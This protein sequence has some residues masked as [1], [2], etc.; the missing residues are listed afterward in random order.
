MKSRFWILAV[1]AGLGPACAP[2]AEE[3]EIQPLEKL[4]EPIR[5]RHKLPALAA[6]VIRDAKVCAL[7]AVG[8]RKADANVPVTRDD[9][10]H[11]GS[12]TKAMTA[13]VL[14][15][16][17]D[18]GKLRWDMTLPEALPELAKDI[19]S[20]YAKATVR[21][22]LA[23]RAGIVP[24]S[25]P[26][27]SFGEFF[28]L[29]GTQRQQRLAYVREILKVPPQAGIGE[30]YIY[31]NAG[32]ATAG[33]IAEHAA[34]TGWQELMRKTLFVP[35]G[36]KTAGFGAMGTP[37]KI[38]QP[39]QHVLIAERLQPIGPGQM[40]DNPVVIDPAGRVHCSLSDWASFVIAHLKGPR[41]AKGPLPIKTDT[42]KMLH[43]PVF[44]GNYAMGWLVAARGWGGGDVLTHAGS[45]TMNYAVVWMAPVRD[46]AVLVVTNLGGGITAKAC[47]EAA[48]ALVRAVPPRATDE[49]VGERKNEK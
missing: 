20:G 22:V 7:G 8:V 1:L 48:A 30:K 40:S 32:Y 38:D 9:E 45:N 15:A 14:A 17:V 18:E 26:G 6:A 5:I 41:G 39:F 28:K 21:H 46:Y 3:A 27:K 37:G 49:P 10:F 42:W 29:A 35:L 44:G 23:H 11:I 43:E 24:N 33:A 36:M 31:S 16:L 2:A 34:D 19:H 12:C 4:L 25:P 13:T 47:D